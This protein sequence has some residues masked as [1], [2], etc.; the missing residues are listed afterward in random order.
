MPY[1]PLVYYKTEFEYRTH[2]EQVYCRCKIMTFDGIPV[3]FKKDDFDHAFYESM[4]AKDDTFSQKR[5]QRIDW[6]KAALDDPDS[7]RYQGWD[8]K[9]KRCDK[10]R[11]VLV[12]M[13]N[14]VVIIGISRKG[15]GRFITAFVADSGRTLKMIR[16]N[17]KWA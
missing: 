16:Q 12:V 7:E 10:R 9:K 13:G 8:S 3:A 11:R 6:I 14:Y 5:A 15:M 17:P 2:F 4:A 1:P